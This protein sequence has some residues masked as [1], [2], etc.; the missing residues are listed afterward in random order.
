M[1]QLLLEEA[2]SPGY[3][4]NPSV[5]DEMLDKSGRVRP[6]WRHLM[7]ALQQLGPEELA[8]RY[9][10]ALRLLRENGVTYNVYGDPDGLNRPWQL[11]PVP[12]VVS[13]NEWFDIEAG[14]LQRAELLNLVL[15]D[16]YGP[17]TL[18]KKNLLPL[19]LIYNHGG[20]LRACDQVRLPGEQQLVLYAADLARGPDNKMW[21]LGDRTQAPSG[22]G[23]ALENRLAMSRV[24]PSLFR[25]AQVHRLARFFQALRAGLN[26]IAPQ[27]AHTPMVVVLTP[28]PLNETFFEHAYLASYLGYPLVQGD[29]LTVRDGYVW[30]KSLTGLQRVDVILRRVDDNY[31]DP[32]ELREDSRLGVPGLLEAA[33]R[34]NVAIANPLGSGILE[35]PGLLAFLPGIAQHFL[36]QPL[37]LNSIAT[38]WCGQAGELSY[39]LANLKRLV[40][41]PIYRQ[42]GEHAVFGHQL[43][44]S[45]LEVWRERIRA[46]PAFYVAQEYESFSTVP[47]MVG[48]G[49]EPRQALLR[50]F[51]VARAGGY[52]LMPGGLTRSAPNYGDVYITNQL[53]SISKD[54]WVIATEPQSPPASAGP[55]SAG[56]P[57]GLRNALPSR[58]ADN[59]F[60]VG[61]NAERA[62]GCVRLLR[63]TLKRLV[64]NPDSDHPD[65][66]P[67]LHRL[68]HCVTSLTGS[69]PGF[70]GKKADDKLL[71]APEPELLA[72]MQDDTRPGSLPNS[73]RGLQQAGYA[74][75][76]LWS[77]D[78]WRVIDEIGEQIADTKRAGK[79]GLWTM[80]EHLDQLVTSLSAFSGLVMESMT[81]GNG[82]LFLDIGRRLERGLQLIS[83]LRTG[84]AEPLPEGAET[85]LIETLLEC[86]DNLICYRQHY[87]SNPEL[88]SFLELLVLDPNNPR[89]L[90]YQIA[91][92]QEHADKLPRETETGRLG[93]AQRLMLEA[94]CILNLT[95][96]DTW[97][98]VEKSGVRETLDQQ[99]SRIYAL[100]AALSDTLTA[101]YFRHGDTPQSLS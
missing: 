82:W 7:E 59:I 75:R 85:R 12:F 44:K 86:S 33:R 4:L 24:L 79:T 101:G 41:K 14:L 97:L 72:L 30:L 78:T 13:G 67:S 50:C 8:H 73:V 19:E 40:I 77:S 63:A 31:C 5:Y 25:D 93:P 2:L 95:D 52:A 15:A 32:L 74:V 60:W 6:H 66:P 88:A 48:D 69:Y 22:A 92:L 26:A 11:D 27:T 16:L 80:Q 96:I 45:Q 71:R 39:V 84:F 89:S 76:D 61:R 57:P 91:R 23:Y 17:R 47:S 9:R 35:N 68:L 3:R 1:S 83:V 64:I 10:E 55:A 87:R 100:L 65:Y 38:W 29:D 51:A 53:G 37:K 90:A 62:E 20:F 94:N 21:V 43:S 49:F 81:R 42:P 54:T 46:R 36:G 56:G 99:L 34:G 98:V 28:G 58:A 18:I 70:F